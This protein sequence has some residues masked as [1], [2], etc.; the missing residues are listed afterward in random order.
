ME[1]ESQVTAR[2]L[3]LDRKNQ[4]FAAG[5]STK[6]AEQPR[7]LGRIIALLLLSLTFG[8]LMTE[9]HQADIR[10]DR[11]LRRKGHR[12]QALVLEK[13]TTSSGQGRDACYITY[14]FQELPVRAAT[15]RTKFKKEV[16][17]SDA[18]YDATLKGQLVAVLYDPSDPSISTM[19]AAMRSPVYPTWVVWL[20][21]IGSA[22][23]LVWLLWSLWVAHQL[24]SKG[25][26]IKGTIMAITQDDCVEVKYFFLSPLGKRI[27]GVVQKPASA[28]N[29]FQV[30]PV[31]AE[32]D[33]ILVLYLAED[34][35]V[36]L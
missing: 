16:M 13:R 23:A 15:I 3:L 2:M 24:A 29:F 36:V 25:I 27:E 28:T 17:V 33:A 5:L 6:T 35:F 12:A 19:E 9:L 8:L 21:W 7:T 4:A 20:W 18:V 14:E 34:A 22:A 11:H 32:N 1:I 30:S 10:L 31:P 26:L